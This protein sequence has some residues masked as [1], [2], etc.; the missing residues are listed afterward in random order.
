[1]PRK[2]YLEF[3]L[4]SYVTWGALLQ[5]GD[6][7]YLKIPPDKY[8]QIYLIGKRPRISCD[9]NSLHITKDG[10]IAVTA[11]IHKLDGVKSIP[12]SAPVNGSLDSVQLNTSYP[13][14]IISAWKEGSEKG[15]S[16]SVAALLGFQPYFDN[17]NLDLEILYIGQSD[18]D[19]SKYRIRDRIENHSTLLKIYSEVIKNYPNDEIWIAL[20]H[21]EIDV[22]NSFG[23]LIESIATPD[24][25]DAHVERY[26]NSELPDSEMINL[27]EAALIRY[28]QPPFNKVYKNN[29]PNSS[30]STYLSCYKLEIRQIFV[31][32]LTD[33]IRC[34]VYTGAISP[35]VEHG[36][37]YLLRSEEDFDA[38]LSILY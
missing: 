11:L 28:F 24:E 23:G 5:Q 35:S 21:F 16:I 12:F 30:H 27:T 7:D 26:F 9:P 3:A 38:L 31:A 4:N 8:P 22:I 15:G 17:E 25:D 1:M 29:F 14:T 19:S 6:F 36:V 13:Y 32:F 33:S 10:H 34:R 20:F 18:S 37:K 2:Y